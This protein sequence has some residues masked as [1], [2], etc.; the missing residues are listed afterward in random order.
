MTRV[1]KTYGQYCG[2]ARALDR[3]GD[4]WTLL[5]VRELLLGP[6]RFVD[7]RTALPGIATNLLSAR[8]RDLLADGLATRR[9][10][11]PPAAASVYELTEVGRDLEPTVLALTRWGG[12]WMGARGEDEFD[13]RW[14]ALALRALLEPGRAAETDVTVELRAD[15]ATVHVRAQNR[16][17]EIGAGATSEPDVVVEADGPTLLGIGAGRVPLERAT[18]RGTAEARAAA[19]RLFAAVS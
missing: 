7:L 6:R 12:N 2:L 1:R 3:V 19:A 13:A 15:D 4:R 9:R 14:L 8:L 18:V 17:L 16:R 5:I 10:L 11:D